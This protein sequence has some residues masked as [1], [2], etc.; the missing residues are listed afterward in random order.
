MDGKLTKWP[1][2]IPTS[3]IARPSKI[4]PNWSFWFE[5]IPSGNPEAFGFR[6]EGVKKTMFVGE[7]RLLTR[8]ARFFLT[9]CTKTGENIPNCH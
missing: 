9:Q 4:Y 8:F 7:K 2:N 6:L 3:S 1:L 5:N